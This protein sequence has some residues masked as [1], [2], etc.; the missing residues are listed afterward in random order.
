MKEVKGGYQVGF[1]ALSNDEVI[2]YA[3]P[4]WNTELGLYTEKDGTKYYYNRQGLLLH[5]GMCELGVSECRLSS[6]INNQKHYTQA[7]R[8]LIEVMSIIGD[9]PYTTYL[10]YTVKRH[11]NVDSHG[12]RT[13]YFSYGVAVIHQSGSWYRFKSSEVLNHYKV[14]QEMRNAYN[15]DMEYLLK[16]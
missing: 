9:D 13:L 10:G 16:R 11:I 7:Q 2:A 5:G 6:A 1:K 4:N 3:V 14:I 12:K 8:R 15:G